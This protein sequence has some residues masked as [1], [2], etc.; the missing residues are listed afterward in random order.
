MN[1]YS[2]RLLGGGV[3]VAQTFTIEYKVDGPCYLWKADQQSKFVL[4][5]LNS[6][7][8]TGK[9]TFL[10][11][12][13]KRLRKQPNSFKFDFSPDFEEPDQTSAGYIPQ[14]PPMVNH[15]K[16]KEILPKEHRFLDCFF[17]ADQLPELSKALK[18]FSGGQRRKLYTCSTLEKLASQG[19]NAAFLLLDETFD[20]LGAIEAK[21]C[22]H[23]IRQKW[24][25]GI[26]RPLHILLVT[27]LNYS[28]ILDGFDDAIKLGLAVESSTST[29][30]VAKIFN[31]P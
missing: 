21:Q 29:E 13:Y 23:S 24:L 19:Q 3:K 14:N 6:P 22:L 17:A 5:L 26:G 16:L 9:T 15:W 1:P 7:S 28:E 4:T 27:H 30:L 12:I 11:E 8:G 25:Q 2:V 20:G 18:D 31:R 10:S